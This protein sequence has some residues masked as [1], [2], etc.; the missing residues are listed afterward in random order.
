[1]RKNS[2]LLCGLAMILALLS[3][4]KSGGDI[5]PSGTASSEEIVS[6]KTS[7]NSLNRS[8][9][10]TI[11]LTTKITELE[12]GLSAVQFQGD[13]AFKDFL[14]EGGASSDTEVMNFLTK[15]LASEKAGLSFVGNPFGCSTFSAQNV[16]GG[17]LFGRNFDWN[18]C[19]ALIVKSALE[20]G[21]A[22]ISTVNTDFIQG[23]D[24]S[25]L[26]D[27][28]QATVAMYA[29]LD[30]MNE[31]GLAVSVNMIQDHDTIDQNTNKPDLTTTT[32]IRLLLNQAADVEEALEL[33]EQYDLHASMG[34]MVHFAIADAKGRSV[35]VEYIR[36]EM[37]V[38]ETPVLTNFYLAQGEK[39]GIGTEQSHTRFDILTDI[40]EKQPVM[41]T[42]DVGDT[43]SSV[44]KKNFDEFES[45][46]WSIVY[47]QSAGS[48]CYFHREN[49]QSSYCFSILG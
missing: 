32:A 30:G 27:E 19:N 33:L 1:M 29:P 14:N 41:D 26:P 4:C 24:F 3:G 12:D 15:R 16:D 21:Y 44:S 46:E 47:D 31:K 9:G 38:I 10:N 48:A 42:N 20:S 7:D 45:T 5:S 39:Q 35:A 49:Y 37:V 18:H 34:Y 25:K 6:G 40:L 11:A 8:E 23:V 13:D 36:N 22:S 2:I 43:L 28:V 17:Y